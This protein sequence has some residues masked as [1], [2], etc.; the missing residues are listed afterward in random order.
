[1]SVLLCILATAFVLA[2]SEPSTPEKD[3]ALIYVEVCFTRHS[4]MPPASMNTRHTTKSPAMLI[5]HMP[6]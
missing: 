3:A 4:S 2:Y 1:M 5:N 6:Q